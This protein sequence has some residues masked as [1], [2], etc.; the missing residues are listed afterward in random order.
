M[1]GTK[2]AH[3]EITSHLG[4]G[5]MGDVYQATDSKLGR[6]VAIKILPAAFAS[7][8]ERL[9]RFRREAQVLAS[10]NHPYIAHIYGIE[11]AGETCCIVLELVDG[12]TLQSRIARGPI[13]LD[14]ALTIAKQIAEALEAAH[15]KG[16]IHRDL[17]P[18][19]VMLTSDG[20]VKVLDFG[21]AKA[22][23]GNAANADFSNSPTL[24]SLTATNAG[25]ILGTAAYMSPEQAKGRGVD[26][27]T[28][29]FAFGCVLFEMLSGKRAFDG[30]DVTD[31]LGA[32]LRMEPDWK[33][34]PDGLPSGVRNL[35]RLYLEKNAKNRRS[36]A[37]DVRLDIEQALLALHEPVSAARQVMESV[38]R[39]LWKRAVPVVLALLVGSALAGAAVWKLR[40][41]PSLLVTR[42]QITLAEG[43]QF[44]NSGRMVVAISPDGARMVYVANSRLYHRAMAELEARPIPGTETWQGVLNPVF[45]PDGRYLVFW[46]VSDQTLKKIALTG[47]SSVTLCA[48]DSPFG[49]SWGEDG[50]VFGQGPKGIMKVSQN[51]GTP[52]LLVRPENDESAH[53]PQVLPG[54]EV[55]LYT[56]AKGGARDQWDAAKIFVQPLKPGSARKVLID[57]GADARYVATG[58]IVYA[59]GGSLFAVPFDLG[60][61]TVTGGQ[62]PV[63]EGVRRSF[64]TTGSAHFSFSSTGSLIYVPGS[65]SAAASAQRTLATLDSR[66]GGLERLKLP[67]KAYAFPRVSPDGKWVAVST[68]DSKE[69]NVWIVDLSGATTPRQLTLGGANR[70]PVWS[71]DG[72]RVA[73]QSDREGDFGIFWQMADGTGTAKRLTKAE[74]GIVHIP[75]SWSRDG[76]NLSYTAVKGAESA[77]WVY[78]IDDNKAKV[79]AEKAGAIVGRSAFSPDG[80]W[81]AYQSTEANPGQIFVQ[82]FPATGTRYPVV[83]GGHPFW[84][85]DGRQLFYNPSAGQI[86]VVSITTR[87]FALEEP[88]RLPGGTS[89]LLSRNPMTDPR[90]WDISRDG[91]KLIGVADADSGATPSSGTPQ[92]QV[93]LNWFEELKQRVPL[94]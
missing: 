58:H 28:D 29:I 7:D 85:R 71:G 44:T 54:G 87:P 77:L 88:T 23:D 32:V 3:Y 33:Q 81:L 26:R 72:E 11:D 56:I 20:K 1:I 53:G 37:T 25:V 66:G 4:S 34:L 93:V 13:P 70:Y 90:V 15:E 62:V 5:G 67:G 10:L 21:L 38:K 91:K 45:S 35:L 76:K 8:P 78:S 89:G 55:L 2:L 46:A 30:E 42:F 59:V 74:Q 48:A 79:F 43:Q 75:D 80:Q 39:P 47:G 63:V 36:D 68:D 52:E 83:A 6:N 14:E 41:G 57:G 49:V 40:P 16:V 51:G 64:G 84:S 22:Y 17:K 12:E 94:R 73:F 27:R 86:A 24:A 18:G 19:N 82:P 31:I 9:S 69:T 61:L 92:I 65:I 50:I 60:R